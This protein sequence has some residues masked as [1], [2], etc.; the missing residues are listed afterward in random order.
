MSSE[1]LRQLRE[2]IVGM[3]EDA[4][5]ALAA[6]AVAAGLDA[7]AVIDGA[8]LEAMEQV[9]ALYEQE[10]YF[11]PEL[12]SAA[13]ALYAALEVLR[14]HVK[15]DAAADA[16][17][18][19]RIVIGSIE[20]DTHDIGKNVVSLI[21]STCGCDVLDLGRDVPA[22]RFAEAAQEFSADIIAVSTL[23]TTT[24]ERL[25]WVIDDLERRGLRRDYLVIVGGRPL[26]PDFARRIGADGYAENAAAALR[27]IRTLT[28]PTP[29]PSETDSPDCAQPSA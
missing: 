17:R 29:V 20:G 6:Q 23:M 15:P 8:C 13:D 11:I 5:A 12:L 4:A 3:D 2:A 1:V 27:L 28:A 9:G 19:P 21:L 16:L 14:P 7:T 10:E 22:A 24:M 26:S 18:R 25:G